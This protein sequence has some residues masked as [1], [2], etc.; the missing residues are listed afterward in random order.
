M[1]LHRV[2]IL[3]Q[4]L[5]SGQEVMGLQLHYPV[6]WPLRAQQVDQQSNLHLVQDEECYLL[7]HLL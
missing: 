7:A 3:F 6:R 1:W 5:G 4:A 2:H